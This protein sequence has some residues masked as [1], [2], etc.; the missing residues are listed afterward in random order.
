MSWALPTCPPYLCPFPASHS[1]LQWPWPH[2]CP[3]LPASGLCQ[4]LHSAWNEQPTLQLTTVHYSSS[5]KL[6]YHR[7]TRL[8]TV[9]HVFCNTLR[10]T[11][12]YT[13]HN[14]LWCVTV[15]VS[16]T[17]TTEFFENESWFLLI[18]ISQHLVGTQWTFDHTFTNSGENF[19]NLFH[20]V[21]SYLK[22]L[23]RIIKIRLLLALA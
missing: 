2:V 16:L 20:S 3:M 4:A 10:L 1:M 14:V 21:F 11:L 19:Q 7:L 23:M 17:N 18:S 12:Y 5:S 13:F 15:P 6:P 8:D 22:K 9:P